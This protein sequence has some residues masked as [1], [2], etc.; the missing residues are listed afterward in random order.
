MQRYIVHVVFV[1]LFL[2]PVLCVDEYPTL[3]TP[4]FPSA[5]TSTVN[6]RDV[7]FTAVSTTQTPQQAPVQVT[8]PV[9][10]TTAKK[11]V[12][13]PAK[14][15]TLS[16]RHLV[17]EYGRYGEQRAI[18]TNNDNRKTHESMG[19]YHP[20]VALSCATCAQIKLADGFTKEDLGE[21]KC[22]H[23]LCRS[24]LSNKNS[25]LSHMKLAH[26]PVK[27]G[28]NCVGCV[29][30]QHNKQKQKTREEQK[31]TCSPCASSPPAPKSLPTTFYTGVQNLASQLQQKIPLISP[32]T[33]RSIKQNKTN[34]DD[35]YVLHIPASGP[36]SAI[37]LADLKDDL[38]SPF[39]IVGD[40]SN[41]S[42]IPPL[43][44]QMLNGT[45][46]VIS[47]YLL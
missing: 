11:R 38:T 47:G 20:C 44:E 22:N 25:L 19:S 34:T 2:C 13:R 40:K 4:S 9:A 5:G 31:A 15:P 24:R 12:T 3:P 26:E 28:V 46:N 14:P 33:R 16:C 41:T 7:H 29:R 43:S 17:C 6:A 18:F 32:A 37:P 21:F 45:S 27:C 36:C 35:F 42:S 10:S 30:L 8:I 39:P 1:V 23:T